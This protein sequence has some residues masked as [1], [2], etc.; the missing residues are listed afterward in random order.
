MNRG[1][2]SKGELVLIYNKALDNQMSGK[3]LLRWRRP[4]VIVARRPSG[5]YIVQELDGV[6]L[7]QPI[8][9]KRLKSYVPRRG[10]NP[11]IIPPEWISTVDGYEEDLL[12]DDS[13]ELRVM[14][15]QA[16]GG[17]VDESCFPK[18]WLLQGEAANEYWRRV[19]E[20][21]ME[22]EAKKKAGI[23]FEPEPEFSPEFV[24]MINED[25]QFWNFRDITTDASGDL[26]R[27]KYSYPR[28]RELF[29]WEPWGSPGRY[30]EVQASSIQLAEA[31]EGE[32]LN[33]GEPKVELISASANGETDVSVVAVE[34]RPLGVE[35]D[36]L[37]L[38]G[39][40]DQEEPAGTTFLGDMAYPP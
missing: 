18:L 32:I 36:V 2:Y 12:K 31:K 26:P 14:M 7:K 9:W 24:E 28:T 22:R 35:K 29:I 25:L 39:G 27:W 17:R 37:I 34:L 40:V 11:V 38:W 5:A 6:V 19:Y 8:A 33:L 3:G 30:Q 13:D 21:W 10:L 4:Y 15:V 20:R 1:E 16:S 23:S